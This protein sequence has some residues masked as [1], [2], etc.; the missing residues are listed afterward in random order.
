ME[1]Y[2]QILQKEMKTSSE[3]NRLVHYRCTS[4]LRLKKKFTEKKH[5]VFKKK[6]HEQNELLSI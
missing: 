2:C 1:I 3:P 6:K 4:T 5:T